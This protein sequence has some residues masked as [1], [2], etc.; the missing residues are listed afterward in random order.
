MDL[1]K[2]KK[3]S[4]TTK[5]ETDFTDVWSKYLLSKNTLPLQTDFFE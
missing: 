1:P 5:A 2:P 4:K 3:K